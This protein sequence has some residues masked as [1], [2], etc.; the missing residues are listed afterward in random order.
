[1]NCHCRIDSVKRYKNIREGEREFQN[2]FSSLSS[3]MLHQPERCSPVY[4]LDMVL[5]LAIIS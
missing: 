1:M 5:R 2:S 3:T 4:V